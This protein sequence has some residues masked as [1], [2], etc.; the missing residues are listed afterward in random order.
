M[1]TYLHVNSP[2]VLQS[3]AYRFIRFASS[4]G[5]GRAKGMAES[6]GEE[7]S[8]PRL[9]SDADRL[10][11]EEKQSVST[12]VSIKGTRS[13]LRLTLEPETPF[14]ELL[15]ALADRLAESPSFFRGASLSVDTSQRAL[16]TSERMQLE[17]LLALY[18]MS[19]AS[20]PSGPLGQEPEHD[21][22]SDTLA[23][24]GTGTRKTHSIPQQ[25]LLP[26]GATTQEIEHPARDSRE[27]E[28]TL[29][30]RRTVRSGQAIHHPSSIV[31]LGDVNPGAEIV[32]GGD[33]IVWGVLRGMVHA[34]Y[35]DNENALVCSLQLAP[36]QLRI[37]HLLS[38]PPEGFEAQPRPEIAAIRK[39]Q[40]VVEA[41]VSGR[42]SR[43]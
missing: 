32:A 14:S 19:V 30:L 39:G 15:N 27:S 24:A 20:K 21:Q 6:M 41:W 23:V 2:H 29:F 7:A 8:R 4:K 34:G 37:A 13:G 38:R 28:D 36:V 9:L 42:A 35:P 25:H 40:I 33:I 1:P 17:D 31:V 12:Y 11:K 22:R 26:R 5:N 43:R 10:K 3:L 16:R 18:Q